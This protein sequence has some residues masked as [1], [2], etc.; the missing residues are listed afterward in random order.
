[1]SSCWLSE[2]PGAPKLP[3]LA[4]GVALLV[5]DM[6]NDFMD[7]DAAGPAGSLPVPG[8]RRLLPLVK[9]LAAATCAAGGVVAACQDWHPPVRGVGLEAHCLLHECRRLCC[10]CWAPAA[11]ACCSS[12][13]SLHAVLPTGPRQLCEHPP[14]APAVRCGGGGGGRAAPT[15]HPLPAALRRTQQWRGACRCG[16]PCLVVAAAC[17]PCR[18]TLTRTRHMHPLPTQTAWGATTLRTWCAR[19]G[20]RAWN[21]SAPSTTRPAPPAQARAAQ[22][23]ELRG[24][25]VQ[26]VGSPKRCGRALRPLWEGTWQG[27]PCCCCLDGPSSPSTPHLQT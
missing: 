26:R 6:Q 10:C 24:S 13:A 25:G 15:G 5:V 1:M 20:S 9:A 19:G 27:M 7:H 16:G 14:R 11:A 22:G 12:A 2:G 21:P 23:G 17:E 3:R 8:A 4:A 18:P